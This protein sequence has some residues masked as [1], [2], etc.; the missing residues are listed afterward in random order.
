MSLPPDPPLK[1]YDGDISLD[2]NK[3]GTEVTEKSLFVWRQEAAKQNPFSKIFESR[4][5]DPVA[6]CGWIRKEH[7]SL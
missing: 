4:I 7:F 6:S 5:S 2:K 3:P 1:N